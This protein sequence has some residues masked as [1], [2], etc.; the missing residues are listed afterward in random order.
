MR[1]Y[2]L[3]LLSITSL[4]FPPVIAA[5]DATPLPTETP[6]ETASP[7]PTPTAVENAKAVYRAAVESYKKADS[8]Y[9]LEKSRYAQSKTLTAQSKLRDA[10]YQF[11]VA[12]DEYIRTYLVFLR[13][14]INAEN[15]IDATEKGTMITKINEQAD[16]YQAH[17]DKIPSAGTLDDLYADSEKDRVQYQKNYYSNNLLRCRTSSCSKSRIFIRLCS[18]VIRWNNSKDCRN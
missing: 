12:R 6:V 8:A 9:Q 4:L 2:L 17:K 5:Q 3:V 11:L 13:E 7:A 15:D 10:N 16:W 1:K 18:I 14:K